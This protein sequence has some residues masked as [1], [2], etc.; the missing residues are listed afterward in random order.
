MPASGVLGGGGGEGCAGGSIGD[1]GG[2]QGSG[3][4][5]GSTR[6]GVDGEGLPNGGAGGS[7]GGGA[8]GALPMMMM[9]WMAVVGSRVTLLLGRDV[10]T[11]GTCIPIPDI[12]KPVSSWPPAA[13]SRVRLATPKSSLVASAAV[14]LDTVATHPPLLRVNPAVHSRH[15]SAS[16][17]RVHASLHGEHRPSSDDAY[18]PIGQVAEQWPTTASRGRNR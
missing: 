7:G 13:M 1:G 11:V 16:R 4:A 5:S 9:R 12:L 6:G 3:G 10:G 2:L 15:V 14:F 18:S 8:G 17:Q